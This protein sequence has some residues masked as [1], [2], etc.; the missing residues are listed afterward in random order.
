[1]V[2]RSFGRC[3][4]NRLLSGSSMRFTIRS[5]GCALRRALYWELYRRISS[6][7]VGVWRSLRITLLVNKSSVF[8]YLISKRDMYPPHVARQLLDILFFF[9]ILKSVELHSA[10][11]V[12]GSGGRVEEYSL[13]PS[14]IKGWQPCVAVGKKVY[15]HVPAKWLHT[16][17]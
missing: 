2:G 17:Q 11:G 8:T 7:T 16:E 3:L 13:A 9:K 12:L 1:M 10:S 14:V 5:F 15:E 6:L 4:R